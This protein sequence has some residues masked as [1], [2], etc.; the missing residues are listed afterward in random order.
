MNS[1]KAGDVACT[2]CIAVAGG[3]C[4][5]TVPGAR[6]G[7]YHLARVLFAQAETR[8]ANR[9]ERIRRSLKP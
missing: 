4:D 8:A 9:A 1:R 7:S 2:V 6:Q 5:L 3:A